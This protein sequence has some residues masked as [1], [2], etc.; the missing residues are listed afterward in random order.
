MAVTPVSLQIEKWL[1]EF[2]IQIIGGKVPQVGSETYSVA[3]GSTCLCRN[4]IPTFNAPVPDN[5][6]VVIMCFVFTSGPKTSFCDNLLNS[7]RPKFWSS[8]SIAF[9]FA[10]RQ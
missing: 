7:G 6:C 2:V 1:T 8:E 3:F 4:S 9:A 10:N 5:A